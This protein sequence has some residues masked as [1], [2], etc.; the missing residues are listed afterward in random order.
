MKKEVEMKRNA[1]K[2]KEG[3][4]EGEGEG[5]EQGTRDCCMLLVVTLLLFS[6]NASTLFIPHSILFHLHA[7]HE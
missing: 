3:V 6:F 4:G 5:N 1:W 2:L 7:I